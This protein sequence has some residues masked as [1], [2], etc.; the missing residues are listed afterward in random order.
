MLPSTSA[1]ERDLRLA[2]LLAE[3]SEQMRQGRPPDLNAVAA[4]HPDLAAELRELWA[5]CCSRTN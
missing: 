1:E 4:Q 3:L 5:R 2:Q